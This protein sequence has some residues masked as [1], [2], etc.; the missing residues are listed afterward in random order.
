MKILVAVYSSVPSWNIPPSYV[1]RL[2]E[3]FPRHEFIH[4][5]AEPGVRAAMADVEVAFMSEMRPHHL[6]TARRLRWIHSPAAGVGG[7]LSPALAPLATASGTVER[8]AF[9]AAYLQALCAL[10]TRNRPLTCP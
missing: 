2:R 10:Q 9:D 6:A 4:V 1:Q 5:A 3:M 8:A 7:M